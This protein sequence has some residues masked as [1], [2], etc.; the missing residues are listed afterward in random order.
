M[1]TNFRLLAV[2]VVLT[3]SAGGCTS[4]PGFSPT[5]E[6]LT[7]L[8]ADHYGVSEEKVIV[9]DV[10]TKHPGGPV[11]AT[12]T[13][14]RAIVAGKR[15]HCEVTNHFGLNAGLLCAPEGQPL[16]PLGH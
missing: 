12:E 3:I 11:V 14:F 7:T 10:R 8:V 16:N 4:T 9:S 15:V 6:K 13:K 1:R 5:P 2:A